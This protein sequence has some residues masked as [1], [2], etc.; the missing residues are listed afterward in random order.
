M[1]PI[2][3]I[4][5]EGDTTYVLALEAQKRGHNLY[6]YQP[7][8][9]SL[10]NGRVMA[11]IRSIT[12]SKNK[13]SYFTLGAPKKTTLNT[14]DIV[15]MR[16]DPPFNMDY[17][18][19]TYL[20]ERIHP[21]TLVIN[22]PTEVRNCPEKLFACNFPKF[23]PPTIV[24]K[25]TDDIIAFRKKH[26]D[27]II[28]PLHG[29]GGANIF[30]IKQKDSNFNAL[31]EILLNQYDHPLMIQRFIP[32]VSKGDKRIIMINGKIA[33][34]FNRIPQKGEIR[35]NMVRGGT[36]QK[37]VL[38][39]QE[40]LI[41]NT[42]SP[43]LTKRGIVLAGVDIIGNYLTEVNITSPTGIQAINALYN[44]NTESLFWDEIAT[45]LQ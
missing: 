17:I 4:N 15:L 16:Q 28:K 32:E 35:A 2:E 25:N 40:K 42:I 20:L 37:T 44:I 31:L 23:M 30:N 27:I 7:K 34:A 8:E 18:T 10:E 41:C 19:Y 29:H 1:D 39:T 3:S 9:L 24:T 14:M 36:T 38:N 5:T 22:N 26:K 43:E 33:G 12:L 45:I 11:T 13:N 21:K 6:Y